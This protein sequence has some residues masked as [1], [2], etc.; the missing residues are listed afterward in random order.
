[1]VSKMTCI[2]PVIMCHVIGPHGVCTQW[3][4]YLTPYK[5]S[6]LCLYTAGVDGRILLRENSQ[7]E[8]DR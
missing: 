8:S 7:G 4:L 6:F 5:S 3:P 2:R 1:M